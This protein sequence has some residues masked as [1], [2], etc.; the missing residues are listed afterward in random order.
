[1][2]SAQYFNIILDQIV[3]DSDR[4]GKT[5]LYKV[6]YFE[7]D[8]NYFGLDL[9]SFYIEAKNHFQVWV[10]LRKHIL[11]NTKDYEGEPIDILQSVFDEGIL[12]DITEE[13]IIICEFLDDTVSYIIKDLFTND[14][15]WVEYCPK[16]IVR[17]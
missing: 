9:D 3:T 4:G 15:L 1:M 17:S 6:C 16:T 5:E 10:L 8:K 13:G 11:E 2:A 12:D 14:T 7:N